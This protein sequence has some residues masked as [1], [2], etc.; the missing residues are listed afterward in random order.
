MKEIK[1][2]P[3]PFCGGDAKFKTNANKSS[4]YCVGFSFEIKCIKC[5]LRYPQSFDIEIFLTENG[6]IKIMPGFENVINH[7]TEAWNR[8]SGNE[9]RNNPCEM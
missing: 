4:H 9:Q 3:C 5:D 7:A 2:K 8:R 1:L 6:E